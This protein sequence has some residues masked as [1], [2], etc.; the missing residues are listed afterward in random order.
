MIRFVNFCSLRISI[1]SLIFSK[2]LIDPIKNMWHLC[3]NWRR[4]RPGTRW[5][6][7]QQF[8]FVMV[9]HFGFR[10][11]VHLSPLERETIFEWEHGY[12]QRASYKPEQAANGLSLVP[13]AV[14]MFEPSWRV[15]KAVSCVPKIS[16]KFVWHSGSNS[17]LLFAFYLK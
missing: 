2:L 5:C 6:P 10:I 7:M 1:S 3:V 15:S 8:Q 14:Q 11:M 13:P 12:H 9:F 16:A 17:S 4:F